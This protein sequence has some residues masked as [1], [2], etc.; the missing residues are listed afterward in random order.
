MKEHRLKK[1]NLEIRVIQ[2]NKKINNHDKRRL[3]FR[4]CVLQNRSALANSRFLFKI[5]CPVGKL[6]EMTKVV[7]G[8]PLGV[9]EV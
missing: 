9:N 5:L 1:M 8:V 3:Q 4:S 7:N 2:K 6:R